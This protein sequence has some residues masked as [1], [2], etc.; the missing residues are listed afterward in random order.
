M[1]VFRHVCG[2]IIVRHYYSIIYY[3]SCEGGKMIIS[4]FDVGTAL[5]LSPAPAGPEKAAAAPD[6]PGGGEAFVHGETMT[7][8]LIPHSRAPEI[9]LPA[10]EAAATDTATPPE[11]GMLEQLYDQVNA[12]EKDAIELEKGLTSRPALNI[13]DGG[14]GEVKKAEYL[15][16]YMKNSGFTS[17]EEI[18]APDPASPD[19][20]HLVHGPPGHG[21]SRFSR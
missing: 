15:K 4:S 8:G 2:I 11:R 9:A 20:Y 13:C 5:T 10:P 7:P 21:S 17:M 6:T 12:C 19:G 16:D 18:K 14:T 3:G 1:K